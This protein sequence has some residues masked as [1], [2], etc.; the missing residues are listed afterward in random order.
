MKVI[1]AN[2]LEEWPDGK[3]RLP[4]KIVSGSLGYHKLTCVQIF[5]DQ[6]TQCKPE[7]LHSKGNG[8]GNLVVNDLE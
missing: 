6:P 5:N 1:D 4:S 2:M 8:L 7:A 3:D